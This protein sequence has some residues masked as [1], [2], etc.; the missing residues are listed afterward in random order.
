MTDDTILPLSFPAVH[1]KKSHG[2][3]QWWA[4][5]L[6]WGRDASAQPELWFRASGCTADTHTGAPSAP[7]YI[8]PVENWSLFRGVSW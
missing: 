5:D 8:A 1:A 6:E 3:L 2:C 4:P 7:R